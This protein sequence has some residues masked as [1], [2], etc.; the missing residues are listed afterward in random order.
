MSTDQQSL[1]SHARYVAGFHFVALGLLAVNL[2]FTIYFV[3]RQP[4]LETGVMLIAALGTMLIGFYTR[5]FAAANQD[6]IIRLEER[7]RLQQLLP[8]DLA[9]RVDQF[10]GAQLVAMRFASDAEL[11]ELARRVIQ[12]KPDGAAIKKMIRTWRPDHMRV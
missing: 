3:I 11:P 4:S 9:P 1:E 8:A 10:T 6:R 12:E 2:L 5:Q 7:L